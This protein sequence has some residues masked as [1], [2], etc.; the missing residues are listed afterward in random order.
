MRNH[1]H[2]HLDGLDAK[3]FASLPTF[4]TGMT[5]P[6]AAVSRQERATKVNPAA[7]GG[8]IKGGTP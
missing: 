4:C 1:Q 7:S 5:P 8:P 6:P 3:W 2:I